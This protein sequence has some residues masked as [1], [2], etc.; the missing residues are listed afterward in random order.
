MKKDTILYKVYD[1]YADGFR[2][3]TIGKTLWLIVI[4]KLLIIFVILKI[5]FFPDFLSTK[6]T[7]DVG[8]SDYVAGKVLH[9]D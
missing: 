2:H 5:F 4:V 1:L 7:D 3:M 6:A 9:T 8:K